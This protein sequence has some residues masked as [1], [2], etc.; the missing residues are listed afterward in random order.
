MGR[1]PLMFSTS[2]SPSIFPEPRACGAASATTSSPPVLS[3][4]E[5]MVT[6]GRELRFHSPAC[7]SLSM[8]TRRS[9]IK[10]KARRGVEERHHSPWR[11]TLPS[12]V[13]CVTVVV[14]TLVT[15][16]PAVSDTPAALLAAISEVLK[17]SSPLDGGDVNCSSCSVGGRGQEHG[18]GVQDRGSLRAKFR[19]SAVSGYRYCTLCVQ[20]VHGTRCIRVIALIPR[21]L[22]TVL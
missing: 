20:C 8:D 5:L 3:T 12:G 19:S 21:I 4:E 1:A 14:V 15:P 10:T 2:K 6:F 7:P 22:G 17:K 18:Q 16:L 11:A 13:R 9:H